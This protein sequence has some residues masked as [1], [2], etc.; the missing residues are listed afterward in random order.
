MI[1]LVSWQFEKLDEKGVWESD[2]IKNLLYH[3][4]LCQVGILFSQ[5]FYTF[6]VRVRESFQSLTFKLR[7]KLHSYV[8][9]YSQGI[10]GT[11]RY[12]DSFPKSV[13]QTVNKLKEVKIFISEHAL[14]KSMLFSIDERLSAQLHWICR[15]NLLYLSVLG[16]L[17]LSMYLGNYSNV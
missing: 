1:C 9:R 10:L 12:L 3:Q 4:G 13:H 16:Y 5:L 15:N 7:Q 11:R 8:E 14:G 6:F 17:C 2:Y